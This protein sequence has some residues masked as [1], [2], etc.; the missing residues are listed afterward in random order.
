MPVHA[1]SSKKPWVQL[2]ILTLALSE[3]KSNLAHQTSYASSQSSPPLSI[4]KLF[5]TAA[6]GREPQV[7]TPPQLVIVSTCSLPP[8]PR[9]LPV[10][11]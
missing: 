3:V 10:G 4:L 2:C 9:P 7:P 6:L 5:Q 8:D 1:T 11:R